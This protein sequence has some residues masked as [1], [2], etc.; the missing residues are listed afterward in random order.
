MDCTVCILI[1]SIFLLIVSMIIDLTTLQVCKQSFCDRESVEGSVIQATGMVEFED[2]LR[3]GV[4]PGG[5]G[6]SWGWCCCQ[7]VPCQ[8][9]FKLCQ[10]PCFIGD[11]LHLVLCKDWTGRRIPTL[12]QAVWNSNCLVEGGKIPLGTPTFLPLEGV[13]TIKPKF[14]TLVLYSWKIPSL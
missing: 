5:A 14:T 9:K 4:L 8:T 2:G 12:S 13:H 7:E 11:K 6:W 1:L 10:V 3:T